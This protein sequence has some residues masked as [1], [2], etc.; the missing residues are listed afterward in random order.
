LWEQRTERYLLSVAMPLGKNDTPIPNHTLERFLGS[1][2]LGEVWLVRG[3]GGVHKAAKFIRLE[4]RDGIKELMA[5]QRIKLI[6]HAHLAQITD[7][8][9]LD[10]DGEVIPDEMIERV[11]AQLSGGRQGDTLMMRVPTT[12]AVAMTLADKSLF[13]LLDEYRQKG[14]N[15][16]PYDELIRYIQ[17]AAKG[18]DFLNQPHE[19]LGGKA[20]QHCDI[21]PQ[22]LLLVG[23]S[24]QIC[25]FGLARL[26]GERKTANNLEGTLAY[27]APEAARGEEPRPTTDQYSLAISYYELSTGRCPFD[28]NVSAWD[29]LTIHREGRLDFSLVDAAEQ[30]VLR[31]ATALDPEKR[32]PSNRAFVQALIEANIPQEPRPAPWVKYA[33]LSVPLLLL[34]VIAVVFWPKPD[35]FEPKP[36]PIELSST[37][38]PGL[39][40]SKPGP[41][42]TEPGPSMSKTTP[43]KSH[44]GVPRYRLPPTL[45]RAAGAVEVEA[46]DGL[47]DRIQVKALADVAPLEMVLVE[48]PG[49]VNLGVQSGDMN[50][51]EKGP[52][53]TLIDSPYYLA[54]HETSVDQFA[55]FVR[56][57]GQ[58]FGTG[59]A[60]RSPDLAPEQRGRLPVVTVSH[61]AAAVFCQ[62][63]GG[64]LPSEA[65]WEYAARGSANYQFPWGET[66]PDASRCNVDFCG[67]SRLLPIDACPDGANEMGML[68]LLGN[69]AEWCLDDYEAGHKEDPEDP[70]LEGTYAVRGCSYAM[71]FG[72]EVRLTW[73]APER[74]AGAVDVGFRLAVPLMRTATIT[75]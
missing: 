24:V 75:E 64:R 34:T 69:A 54:L 37:P 62:W 25:D 23:D 51:G 19:E 10:Q 22:N 43:R 61:R 4:Y 17:D 1:G 56:Q 47:P 38:E 9:L 44:D 29:V 7:V 73:R 30:K 57:T 59:W 20:L 28:E 66:V 46:V 11:S 45:D 18:I 6:R 16:I 35:P 36:T 67:D 14:Q 32:Y 31:K 15:G 8:W 71:T 26:V 41:S 65:E 49:K 58:E 40:K 50:E 42:T 60:D 72:P 13:E 74:E 52:W 12:L 33:A 39:S 5:I 27:I 55:V 63:A 2:A 68:N 48:A 70:L 3:P 21:K 53:E